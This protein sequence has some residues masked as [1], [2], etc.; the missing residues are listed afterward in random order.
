M[1]SGET[2]RMFVRWAIYLPMS[3]ALLHFCHFS[4]GWGIFAC[5]LLYSAV[6]IS[7]EWMAPLHFRKM[8]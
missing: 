8:A 6:Y 1:F 3:I 5:F 4:M 2:K 7:Y